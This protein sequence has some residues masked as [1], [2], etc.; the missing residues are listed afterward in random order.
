MSSQD[1]WLVDPK[2]NRFIDT[3]LRGYLDMSGGHLT[4]RNNN[5]NVNN[6]DISLNGRLLVNSD[7]SLNSKLFV[8]NDVSMNERLFVGSDVSFNSKMFVANDVSMNERLMVGNDVS[9]NSKL[10]VA[11]DV[12]MNEKLHVANDVIFRS[13]FMV[14]GDSSFN[15][16]VDISGDLVVRGTLGVYQRQEVKVI[17][18]TV[19]NYQLIITEDISLNGN[20]YVKDDVSLNSKLF[21]TDDVCMNEMLFVG[22][23]VSFNSDLFVGENTF[24]NKKLYV[25]SDV[26]M[27]TILTVGGDVSLN[28]K[29]YVSSDVSMD[30]MLFVGSDVSMNKKL[31]IAGDVSMDTSL[32][33]GGNVSVNELFM[34]GN[35]VSF[36]SNLFVAGDLSLN[37]QLSVGGDVSMNNKLYVTGDVS[38]DAMLAVGGD[39]STSG[40]THINGDVSMN[41]ML[42]VGGDTTLNSILSVNDDITIE[43]GGII[44][45]DILVNVQNLPFYAT[46]DFTENQKIVYSEFSN[47]DRVF[48]GMYDISASS[49][50]GDYDPWN[51]FSIDGPTNWRSSTNAY[52]ANGSPISGSPI[53][54]GVSGEY[55]D[56]KLPFYI[57]LQTITIQCDNFDDANNAGTAKFVLFGGDINNDWSKLLTYNG[58]TIATSEV[59]MDVTNKLFTNK[60]RI[61][62]NEIVSAT[63]AVISKLAFSGN[64]IGSK[65]TIDNGN[66]GIGNVTPRSALEIT[67]DMILSNAINGTNNSGENQEHGRIV[68]AGIGHDISNNNHSSYIR[69]YFE[70]DTSDTSGNLAFGTSDGV[71]IATDK[72]IIHATGKNEFVTDVSINSK[73]VVGS[74]VRFNSNINAIGDVSMDSG[75]IVGGDVSLNSNL[76]VIGDVFMD[77]GLIVGGDVS[78]NSGL[79]VSENAV[80]KSTTNFIGDVSMNAGLS[81]GSITANDISINT[82][83][84]A[85]TVVIGTEDTSSN[86]ILIV[87]GKI[88]ATEFV[89]QSGDGGIELITTKV[90]AIK[91]GTASD[92]NQPTITTVTAD[93]TSIVIKTGGDNNRLTIDQYGNTTFYN[94]VSMN[95]TL[96]VGDDVSLNSKLYVIGDVSMDSSLIVGGNVSLNNELHVIG[97]VSMDSVLAVGGNAEFKSSVITFSDVYMNS[98]LTVGGEVS[99]DNNLF[100]NGDVS[101]NSGL[102]VVGNT[103]FKSNVVTFGDVSMNS[104]LAVGGD[105][106]LNSKLY[107]DDD[108]SFNSNITVSGDL[109]IYGKLDVNQIQ[110]TNTINTTVNDYTLV[111]TEDLSINGGLSVN[112]DVSLNGNANIS[113]KIIVDKDGDVIIRNK[114][115]V[116]GD[117]VYLSTMIA[118]SIFDSVI[119]SNNISSTFISDT[120]TYIIKSSSYNYDSPSPSAVSSAMVNNTLSWKSAVNGQTGYTINP[121]ANAIGDHYSYHA[122]IN[123]AYYTNT[124]QGLS[125]KGEYIEVEFPYDTLI[126]GY[127]LYTDMYQVPTFGVLLG[128]DDAGDWKLIHQYSNST[129][130]A[131]SIY[132]YDIVAAN[133]FQTK[134]IRFVIDKISI[135]S[136]PSDPVTIEIGSSEFIVY[137]YNVAIRYINFSGIILD[138]GI[139]IGAGY[140]QNTANTSMGFGTLAGNTSGKNNIAFGNYTLSQTTTSDN[141][142]V[143][144]NS[145]VN[146]I[147]GNKNIGIGSD[148]QLNNK[149]GSKNITIGHTSGY[150]NTEGS[151]NTFVGNDSGYANTSGSNNTF[152]GG[153]AGDSNIDGSFNTFIGY[154]TDINGSFSHSTAI[155]SDATVTENNQIVIGTEDDNVKIPG[156]IE[157]SGI[158]SGDVSFNDDI[159]VT[160]STI[161]NSTLNVTGATTLTGLNVTGQSTLNQLE[162][163]NTSTF[164]G[165]LT[166][167]GGLQ[168]STLTSTGVTELRQTLSVNNATTLGNTLNVANV[169]TLESTLN[170]SN[171]TTLQSRLDVNGD[172]SLNEYLT[173]AKNLNV[174]GNT[175]I[176]TLTTS[177][178]TTIDGNFTVSDTKDINLAN[179]F[180]IDNNENITT[181]QDN[182]INILNSGPEF[183]RIEDNKIIITGTSATTEVMDVT[184][185]ISASNVTL[186][187]GGTVTSSGDTATTSAST[188][189]GDASNGMGIYPLAG[190]GTT[191]AP[192][193]GIKFQ[194]FINE[195]SSGL[196]DAFTIDNSGNTIIN[197][198]LTGNN[199]TTIDS[200]FNVT[201][202]SSLNNLKTTGDTSLN[203]LNVINS[204]TLS[205]TLNVNGATTLSST[206]NVTG[207]STLSNVTVSSNLNVS[208][209]TTL[210]SSLDVSG[211]STFNDTLTVSKKTAMNSGV[212]I[213][214]NVSVSHGPFTVNDISFGMSGLPM[215]IT[216]TFNSNQKILY[217]EYS[218]YSG[219]DRIFNG[220]YDVSASSVNGNGDNP[221]WHVFD[222]A[223]N[224]AWTS[225]SGTNSIPTSRVSYIRDIQQ[226]TVDISCEYIQI[227]LPFYIKLD[228]YVISTT[229]TVS[230]LR[231]IGLKDDT[232]YHINE[233]NT[234][235]TGTLKATLNGS[236]TTVTGS[237]SPFYTSNSPF[238]T[239]TIRFIVPENATTSADSVQ[240]NTLRINGDILGS[241][242]HIDNGNLGV[243]TTVPRSAL[244]VT[245]DMII[246]KPINGENTS[247]SSVEHGRIVWAGIGRDINNNNNS[248]YIRSYFE[249]DTYDTSGNLAFGTSDGVNSAS[250]KFV[251]NANG[252]NNFITDVSMDSNLA[253]N[254]DVSFNHLYVKEKVW[255]DG[256]VGI[257]T[258]SPVVVVDINDTGALRIPVGTDNERPISATTNNSDFFGSIRYNTGKSQ[259]EGYGPG[260]SWAALGGVFNLSQNT[261]ILAADPEPDSSNDEL[262]FYTSDGKRMVITDNG[263]VSM[264]E[265]LM[266]GNDVSFNS[267][268]FVANDVSMNSNVDISGNLTIRGDLSV[269][270]TTDTMAIHTTVNDYTLI[271]TEDISLNGELKVSGDV[272][273]NAEMF[274]AGATTCSSTLYVSGNVGIGEVSS[275]SYKLTIDGDVN[276]DSYNAG[277]DYRIKENVVSISD[278]SYNIDKLRPVTY[279]NTKMERQDFGVI[280][281]ELQEQ[282]PFLVTGEK[283]G[284]NHQAVNYNGLIGLL[285]NEVQ[286]LKKRVQEL[287]QSKP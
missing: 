45:N 268:M 72:Y 272:S 275:A 124:T 109:Q 59:S 194:P 3:Y 219:S 168:T 145:L 148:T 66:I 232:F 207:L 79:N 154:N 17:N 260:G 77:T 213:S 196:T 265:R 276:A 214:G 250:D 9:L 15:S 144:Y 187:A 152:I 282:L 37:N 106:S 40:K 39:M 95:S 140:S 170:V 164:T 257:G 71:N 74:D 237:N 258:A 215:S 50:Q 2:S 52:N 135:A 84:V 32:T 264:N 85:S 13:K 169:T 235:S 67:G 10:F 212:D 35:D 262:T 230:D 198:T 186:K 183:I 234:N 162:V 70:S 231:V 128:E 158:F 87:N 101:I 90:G 108:V 6:G 201:G 61:V 227:T 44:A 76:H 151:S 48:N 42:T 100:I 287:E 60:I 125:I 220:V 195:S 54:L 189:I 254:G 38:M 112:A 172:V 11:N 88:T 274:V 233:V 65:V 89:L 26:S 244:E 57:E 113:N 68:W 229:G 21:V 190:T 239:D 86:E 253:V 64:V 236:E 224:S 34:V 180:V 175:S 93:N 205:S 271:V 181:I 132:N 127:T 261:K 174:N 286:Q 197:G 110:N 1:D 22:N 102:V 259:F 16:N 116:I 131:N 177:G 30:N 243:G 192:Y 193:S 94:D 80:F 238:Y 23:D 203:N 252:I 160:G 115:L 263:D 171:A 278:T 240:I 242:I 121:Y 256:N 204:S 167:N 200:S 285:L 62:I 103:D 191:N 202:Y 133:V 78:I 123:T 96:F 134:K 122:N 211:S 143:G 222:G 73:L 228:G 209:A 255:V 141:I 146:N 247:G 41:A 281:H 117:S 49:F 182:I 149:S 248:S 206:L 218:E 105:V 98:G 153:N 51:A 223:A 251:I 188:I 58:N 56:I 137:N 4:L 266:V 7:A 155:G 114:N 82:L 185:V 75:L 47:S 120:D 270:Q 161:L 156:T 126:D 81:I 28:S 217:S 33:V 104:I 138:T 63:Y 221:P 119:P 279:T 150:S 19:N 69:S 8:A 36:N 210:S 5:I 31:Y 159:Q 241:K 165:K 166:A 157:L 147:S 277:S 99:L 179:K 284:E 18:T 55:L 225:A 173:V 20:L 111:V 136:S 246:S 176:N 91:L 269:Y 29:L 139:S 107:V 46:G 283:D 249:N 83:N 24:L 12:S 92:D 129:A 118:N 25:A 178:S 199:D 53:T 208:N 245:G 267:K 216:G 130:T 273:F 226:D 14:E 280:A 142:A 163:A 97:D 27:D 184:G 43:N